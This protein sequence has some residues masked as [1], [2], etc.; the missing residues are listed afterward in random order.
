MQANSTGLISKD[1]AWILPSFY[2]PNWWKLR[3]STEVESGCTDDD[4][5]EI[6]ESV[7]FVDNIKTPPVV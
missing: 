5:R 7:I 4:M 6:M 1:H 2:D 3:K